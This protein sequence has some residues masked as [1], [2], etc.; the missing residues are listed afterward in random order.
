MLL[1]T[2]LLA[3]GTLLLPPCTLWAQER[4]LPE[5][6]QELWASFG[7]KG[8]LPAVFADMIGEE[9]RKR[10]RLGAELGYRSTDAFFAGRQIYLD[11]DMRYKVSKLVD[12]GIE[13]RFA[14]LPDSKNRQRTGLKVMVSETFDR[15]TVGYRFSYQH[16]YREWGEVREVFRNRFEAAYDIPKFQ[17]DPEFSAEFF[18][19]AGNQGWLYF[20]TRYQLGTTWSPTKGHDLGIAL[21]HDRERGVAWPVYRWIYSL[22]YSIDLRK[23]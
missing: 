15:L 23:A 3:V 8:Q 4:T 21:V 7:L 12:I 1:R 9:A 20:G 16:N 14:Y 13:Q 19:W 2:A 18:T 17:L 6:Q 10:I 5:Q 22:S 11:L